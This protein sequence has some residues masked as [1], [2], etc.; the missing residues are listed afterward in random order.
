M[1]LRPMS[2]SVLLACSADLQDHPRL[3]HYWQP[4]VPSPVPHHRLAHLPTT[5]S[6]YNNDPATE[7]IINSRLPNSAP[8]TKP[9][10]SN[11]S[12][13]YRPFLHG[14]RLA[15]R[16]GRL[17]ALQ[18]LSTSGRLL[19]LMIVVPLALCRFVFDAYHTTPSAGHCGEC[20]TLH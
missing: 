15:F 9:E 4:S 20:K 11:V 5:P 10:L 13:I 7:Y 14:Q 12:G 8:W 17:V 1:P 19:Q 16:H 6:A 3:H 2:R 18:P